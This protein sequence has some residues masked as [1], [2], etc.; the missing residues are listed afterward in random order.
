MTEPS[1]AVATGLVKSRSFRKPKQ[2]QHSPSSSRI[3]NVDDVFLDAE[4]R[5][6][7]TELAQLKEENLRLKNELQH[8]Q[9]LLRE[10]QNSKINLSDSDS[11]PDESFMKPTVV[12]SPSRRIHFFP[13]DLSDDDD[14]PP[15]PPSETQLS[16]VPLTS[17][18]KQEC[19]ELTSEDC[20]FLYKKLHVMHD[21]LKEKL[22]SWRN[23]FHSLTPLSP[24]VRFAPDEKV[25][26]SVADVKSQLLSL[27]IHLEEAL[28]LVD[29]MLEG[30]NKTSVNNNV[31]D[32]AI[33]F[34]IPIQPSILKKTS[35]SIDDCFPSLNTKNDNKMMTEIDKS[36]THEKLDELLNGQNRTKSN[37]SNNSDD[38]QYSVF[39]D[40]PSFPA[41]THE[42]PTYYDNTPKE[43]K[44]KSNLE[45]AVM[46]FSMNL[47]DE[48]SKLDNEYSQQ[49]SSHNEYSENMQNLYSNEEM[50]VCDDD[51]QGDLGGS[52]PS[53][54]GKRDFNR[55]LDSRDSPNLQKP[56]KSRTFSFQRKQRPQE[57]ATQLSSAMHN[58]LEVINKCKETSSKSREIVSTLDE[59]ISTF[60]QDDHDYLA[61]N[62]P[63]NHSITP[64]LNRNLPTKMDL[65][66]T[67]KQFKPVLQRS[68]SRTRS[69]NSRIDE[70]STPKHR[71]TPAALLNRASMESRDINNFEDGKNKSSRFRGT[72]GNIR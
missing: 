18:Q 56:F 51:D 41:K 8:T 9:D 1:A 4:G 55:V 50:V 46:K 49:V 38:L 37:E 62:F 26:A 13:D 28:S 39:S 15:P 52:L 7:E 2:L 68:N 24:T 25:S 44:K 69:G 6:L 59:T 31:E 48:I 34:Q 5:D 10:C 45:P 14:D 64:K 63:I 61:S 47:L 57:E 58:F 11:D 67:N 12:K 36:N 65:N 30:E 32:T 66:L 35:D 33:S 27:E 23:P 42:E 70:L 40:N 72:S 53:S 43:T 22:S 16:V 29:L 71:N 20:E 60:N 54:T 19:S 3:I 21:S 17:I